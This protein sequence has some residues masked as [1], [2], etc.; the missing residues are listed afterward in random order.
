MSNLLKE[1]IFWSCTLL[2][3]YQ[4]NI[5]PVVLHSHQYLVSPVF[6]F[7]HC[8]RSVVGISVCGHSCIYLMTNGI[9]QLFTCL[10][11]IWISS[12]IFGLFVFRQLLG[13]FY[14]LWISVSFNSKWSFRWFFNKSVSSVFM[15]K[16]FCVLF[17]TI[18]LSQG[19][20]ES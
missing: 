3:S 18:C 10:L 8:N 2:C 12:F 20:K 13:F 19:C 1:S 17:K 15:V 6:Y 4:Q 7:S 11:A 14:V 5:S 9:E 16:C